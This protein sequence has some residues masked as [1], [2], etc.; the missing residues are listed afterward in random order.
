[1]AENFKKM[2]KLLYIEHLAKCLAHRRYSRNES[3]SL[4]SASYPCFTSSSYWILTAVFV[5]GFLKRNCRYKD[6][7]FDWA[8]DCC[9]FL[10]FIDPKFFIWGL[11]T[12]CIPEQIIE[13]Y[14]T[15]FTQW[16]TGILYKHQFWTSL[17]QHSLLETLK[18]MMYNNVVS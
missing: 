15:A 17:F 7:H 12:Y 5:C 1:M 6:S 18:Q 10:W 14:V 2:N 4:F 3:C 9:N 11:M 13:S 16:L 8:R